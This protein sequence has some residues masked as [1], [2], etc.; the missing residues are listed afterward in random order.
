[1][2]KPM[3][4]VRR[5]ILKL[6]QTYILKEKDKTYTIF[7]QQFLP[8]LK[9]LIDDYKIAAQDA[10]DPEVLLLFSTMIKQMGEQL[11]NELPIIYEGLCASTLSVIQNDFQLYP[12]FR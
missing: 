8:S 2:V 10:R 5:D 6:I 11:H 4:A 9:Q 7:Y 3:K 1:M 12:D